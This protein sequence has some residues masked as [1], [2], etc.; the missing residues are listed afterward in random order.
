MTECKFWLATKSPSQ[1]IL[2]EVSTLTDWIKTNRASL[3]KSLR[4]QKSLQHSFDLRSCLTTATPVEI[5]SNVR[6]ARVKFAENG[7]K[8]GKAW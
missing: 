2:K 4:I 6:E 3:L 8:K 1:I 5:K 7:S